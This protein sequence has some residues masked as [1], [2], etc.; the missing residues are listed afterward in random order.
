MSYNQMMQQVKELNSKLQSGEI[1]KPNTKLVSKE[2]ALSGTITST[3]KEVKSSE[4]ESKA[5]EAPRDPEINQSSEA[6]IAPASSERSQEDAENEAMLSGW[7]PREKF[8]GNPADYVD[9]ETFLERGDFRLIEARK[10]RAELSDMAKKNDELSGMVKAL[11]SDIRDAEER[12]KQ[13]KL[14]ELEEAKKAA[15]DA[16]DLLV[17]EAIEQEE[18]QI[19]K[20]E[21]IVDPKQQELVAAY[22]KAAEKAPW[23]EQRNTDP[24]AAARWSE[25]AQVLESQFLKGKPN[26]SYDEQFNFA[27]NYIAAKY[28][29]MQPRAQ[30]PAEPEE[31]SPKT[32]SGSTISTKSAPSRPKGV[33]E[34]DLTETQRTIYNGLK[35]NSNL[36]VTPEKY[37]ELLTKQ[38]G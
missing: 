3:A 2:Q 33:T 5:P 34:R 11:V 25:A 26:A 16:N 19:K 18:K 10:L 30:I 28:P 12:G 35:R 9:A 13:K 21:P 8:K 6:S 22:K 36:G 24:I 37:L 20:P 32:I 7:V 14:A 15:R 31:K 1:A 27:I 23:F 38:R 29:D 4:P 17:Y